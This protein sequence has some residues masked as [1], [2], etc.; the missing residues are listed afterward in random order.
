MM[1]FWHIGY[2]EVYGRIRSHSFLSNS[3]RFNNNIR[4]VTKLDAALV[5][6]LSGVGLEQWRY[7]GSTMVP[8][9]WQTSAIDQER[10]LLQERQ[11]LVRN[12]IHQPPIKLTIQTMYYHECNL[13]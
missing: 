12:V 2:L 1:K 13:N 11:M 4:D 8:S 5:E 6:Q 7:F 10:L 3:I 9:S